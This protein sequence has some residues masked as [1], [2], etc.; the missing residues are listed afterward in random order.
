MQ[1]LY[2][3]PTSTPKEYNMNIELME[4]FM[5]TVEKT[6]IKSCLVLKEGRLIHEYYK[7]NKIRDNLQRIN[8]C[9]KS[10]ISILIG[11][12]IDKDFILS[13]NVTMEHYFPDIVNNQADSRKKDITIEQLLTMT[14]GLDW[15]EFG[16]WNYMPLCLPM[17]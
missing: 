2:T 11:I 6:K 3:W 14:V 4:K 10:I 15:P 16:E 12:A 7:S 5:K 13:I 8:S 17:M 9:T 1:N